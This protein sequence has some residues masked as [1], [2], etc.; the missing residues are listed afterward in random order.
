MHIRII[1]V[2]V[3]SVFLPSLGLVQGKSSSC[4]RACL[5]NYIDRYVD[6]MLENDPSREFFLAIASLRK[7][8]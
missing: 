3:I 4:N 5:E 2:A 7:M 8:G 1:A 6:A